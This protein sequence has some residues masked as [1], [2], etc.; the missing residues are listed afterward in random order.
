MILFLSAK[1]C[2]LA[3]GPFHTLEYFQNNGNFIWNTLSIFW[4]KPRLSHGNTTVG[5][6]YKGGDTS[7]DGYEDKLG[8]WQVLT[9]RGAWMGNTS[10]ILV[11]SLFLGF[12]APPLAGKFVMLQCT[13]VLSLS[14]HFH[15]AGN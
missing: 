7:N 1:T 11:L 15:W 6:T 13:V 3:F 2:P 4:K 12:M 9:A 8:R 14:S 5:M 10:F